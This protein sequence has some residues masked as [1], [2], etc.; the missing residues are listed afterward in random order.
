MAFLQ[1][2]N[3]GKLTDR[4]FYTLLILHVIPLFFGKYFITQDGPSHLYNAVILKNLI[5]N[6]QS[7]YHQ[8][9]NVNTTPNPNWLVTAFYLPFL[10]FLPP[11]MAE[12]LFLLSY[13]ILLP[14]SFRYLIRQINPQS[15]FISL[16][17]FPF[18][19]NITFY[20]G[21][22]NFCFS[23]IFFC[24]SVGYWISLK[25][26]LNIKQQLLFILLIT[27]TFF[28]HPISIFMEAMLMGVILISWFYSDLKSKK[29]DNKLL[30]KRVLGLIVGFLPSIVF[31][32]MF[33]QKSG[34]AIVFTERNLK[35]YLIYLFQNFDIS[36]F[37]E[38]DLILNTI[39]VLLLSILLIYN[40][41]IRKK[42]K[43]WYQN[44]VLYIVLLIFGF[45]TFFS[46]EEFAG[47]SVIL[48]RLVLY[49]NILAIFCL[50]IANYPE[51]GKLY[52]SVV[53]FCFAIVYLGF[54]SS[55]F[56]KTNEKFNEYM[57][58]GKY[59][60]EGKTILP[61]VVLK[62]NSDGSPLDTI[63][64]IDINVFLHASN[65][66]ALERNLVSFEN[67]EAAQTYFPIQWKRG[68]NPGSY[69]P[70]YGEN[71]MDSSIST[72]AKNTGYWPDY[73]LLWKLPEY[74]SNDNLIL[75]EIKKHYALVQA[76]EHKYARLFKRL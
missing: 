52:L 39:M 65:Y 40:I 2:I 74:A 69:F 25:G 33:L 59:I 35:G 7:I 66:I 18:I 60:P 56:L 42:N 63:R 23:V 54:R 29:G 57:S 45:I 22:F 75:A 68:I 6:S 9:F 10:A 21:F 32:F 72:F 28:S 5:F 62:S 64:D 12:K 8:Y 11:F 71:L 17:I 48:V 27:I 55:R 73:I 50:A 41:I 3:L 70:E 34:S 13:I 46:P 20:L 1:N 19:Y 58:I 51:K 76:T 36:Y 38:T 53:F 49:G 26:N 14:L 15:S 47:G 30:M 61:F 67:Y 16:I 31:F 43:K 4:L 24:Y 44:D 37:G